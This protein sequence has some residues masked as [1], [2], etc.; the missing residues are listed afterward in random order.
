VLPLPALLAVFAGERNERIQQTLELSGAYRGTAL[1]LSD[2]LERADAY[3]GGD[4]THGVVEL[5]LLV[6]DELGLS[7]RSRRQVELAA[8]LHDVG[9]IAIPGGIIT[10]PGPLTPEEWDIMRTHTIE[11]QRMLDRVGGAL[12]QVGQIVRASHERYDGQGYPDGLAGKEIPRE[13]TIV[14]ACD[15]YDA[16]TTDRPYRSARTP[17][18]ALSEM[19]AEAGGQ[20]DPRVVA[21]LERT[22]APILEPEQTWNGALVPAMSRLGAAR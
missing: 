13:A 18:A 4:H 20:F 16:M 8:L 17:R 10:K 2:L 19:R 14:A 3:T 11:G 7:P 15:A 21:A 6:A 5:S 9:K 1:L 22:L 12:A